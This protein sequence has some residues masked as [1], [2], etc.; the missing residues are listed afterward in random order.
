MVIEY[1]SIDVV[2]FSFAPKTL[3]LLVGWCKMSFCKRLEEIDSKW[4]RAIKT[5][6]S[7]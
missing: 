4:T 6:V 7:Y 2:S 3:L 5:V 1:S